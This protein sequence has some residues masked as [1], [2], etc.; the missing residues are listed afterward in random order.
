MDEMFTLFFFIFGLVFGSFFNVVGLRIPKNESIVY[1]NSHCPKCNHELSWYENIPVLSYIILRGKCRVCKS[2]ISTIYPIMELVTGILFAFSFHYFGW[3]QETA[4]AILLSSLLVIITV[5]DI[6]YMM[7]SD[8]VL[9]FFF[10]AFVIL[11][12][13]YPLSPWWDSILAAFIGFGILYLLG[14]ISRGGM[15]GGD[16]KLLFVLG[17]VLG[18]KATLMTLFLASLFGALFGLGVIVVKGYQKRTPI[19]FGP[20]IGMGALFSYFFSDMLIRWYIGMF[21]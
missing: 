15:G 2:R 18:T 19:P 3:S 5:S 1:P 11:R 21:F 10:I 12:I 9:V 8:K 17:I 13:V 7:I 4:A 20:F 6:A 16:I 14:V